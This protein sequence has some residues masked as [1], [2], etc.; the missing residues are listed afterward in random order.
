[1][2]DSNHYFV[3]SHSL[4]LASVCSDACL[5]ALATLGESSDDSA[6]VVSPYRKASV[7]TILAFAVSWLLLAMVV[8]RLS[9]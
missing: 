4:Q 6:R 7:S 8:V 3:A 9:G 2:V 5:R 1:M